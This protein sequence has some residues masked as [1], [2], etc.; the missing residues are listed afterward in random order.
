MPTE[1]SLNLSD[2]YPW[3][4]DY[5]HYRRY[6]TPGSNLDTWSDCIALWYHETNKGLIVCHV[7]P[8]C[9]RLRKFGCGETLHSSDRVIITLGRECN[10][11]HVVRLLENFP[12]SE[13]VNS[14]PSRHTGFPIYYA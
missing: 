5:G 6:G 11:D 1:F 2:P 4:P 13:Y 9:L 3:L 8:D 14:M 10:R 7:M 12:E